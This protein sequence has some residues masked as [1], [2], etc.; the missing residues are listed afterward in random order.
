MNQQTLNGQYNST[1]YNAM[2]MPEQVVYR[3]PSVKNDETSAKRQKKSKKKKKSRKKEIEDSSDESEEFI[4][5][6]MKEKKR[7]KVK[8]SPEHIKSHVNSDYTDQ[9]SFKDKRPKKEIKK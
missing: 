2:G 6:H 7:K 8:K 9:E 1:M 3:N 5:M 4:E